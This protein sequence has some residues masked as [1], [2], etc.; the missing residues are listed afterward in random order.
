[1][2]STTEV[3]VIRVNPEETAEYRNLLEHTFL[4][5]G[6]KV[7]IADKECG[8]TRTRRLRREQRQLVKDRGFLPKARH[9]NVNEEICRFCL[10][11]A[12]LTGC[13]GLKHIQT[14][15][16]TKIDTDLSWCVGDGACRRV[17]ACNSFE[18]I[19]IKRKRPPK[20]RVPEL[21]LDDIPEPEKRPHGELWRCCLTG[22][23]GMG[24]GTV[25]SIVV[26]A[27]HYEGYKVVFVD[28]KGLAIRNGGVVSQVVY[29]IA[30]K[31]VTATIPYGK[32]D[33]L[34]GV[35]ILEAARAM[36]P[37]GRIR[38]ASPDTTAAVINTDKIAT[39]NGIM[40]ADDFDPDALE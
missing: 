19:T 3:P 2:A 38:A 30:D 24:I 31:P 16:G 40:G 10:A 7:I 14:D 35:D 22:V 5:D 1:L 29:N 13:P 34:L 18:R 21:H 37:S 11:C 12:E 26:R 33:L 9:M 36:D 4:A 23:G 8:I 20:S 15:Y 32:A 17:G 28:K 39:F 25:T 27:G 6:V